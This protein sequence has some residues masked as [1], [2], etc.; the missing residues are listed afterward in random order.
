MGYFQLDEPLGVGYPCPGWLR[1]GCYPDEECQ[2]ALL[3]EPPEELPQPALLEPQPQ[4]PSA[5]LEPQGLEQL[6]F[7]LL[8]L[9]EP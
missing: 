2:L 4:E 3:L 7:L 1:T 5:L 8:G 6:E 9:Q